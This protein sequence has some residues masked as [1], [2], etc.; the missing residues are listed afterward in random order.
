MNSD[1]VIVAVEENAEVVFLHKQNGTGSKKRPPAGTDSDVVIV[2]GSSPK[3]RCRKDT[4]HHDTAAKNSSSPILLSDVEDTVE[5]IVT[6]ETLETVE[7]VPLNT[8]N[9][10][11]TTEQPLSTRDRLPNCWTRC[12][13]C[14]PTEERRYHLI[15]V[16]PQSSEWS[17][18]SLPLTRA[19]FSVQKVQR[20]QNM[21]LW[22]RLC[23]EKG[24]MLR[25]RSD[26]NMQL[27]YHTSSAQSAVICEEGLDNRLSRNGNFGRGIYF[28]YGSVRSQA[29]YF[30]I[31]SF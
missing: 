9:T 6:Q 25:Q 22:E 17:F 28:R 29:S 4:N 5:Q 31:N 21:G 27:L 13:T 18:V 2:G 20:I 12:P 3:Q 30:P 24:L 10:L 19:Q 15:S 11:H 7:T 23:V 14:S 8:T 16:T 1:V 26:V